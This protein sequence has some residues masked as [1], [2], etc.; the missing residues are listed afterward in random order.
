[1]FGPIIQPVIAGVVGSV[2]ASAP[3][4]PPPQAV[5]E[6][7]VSGGPPISGGPPNPAPTLL[8]ESLA[9][10]DANLETGR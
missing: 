10:H 4:L 7:G 6:G 9:G 5:F 1:M 2:E 8:A 3:I